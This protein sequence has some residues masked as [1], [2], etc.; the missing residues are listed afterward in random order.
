MRMSRE[1]EEE[2]PKAT[3]VMERCFHSNVKLSYALQGDRNG[4]TCLFI[5]EVKPI[6]QQFTDPFLIQGSSCS[7]GEEYT[8]RIYKHKE[9]SR[10]KK[11][12]INDHKTEKETKME[13]CL[14]FF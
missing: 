8:A 9:Q 1:A 7:D 4:Q 2:C 14:L 13:V 3:E 10:G 12:L 11:K 5:V 6:T